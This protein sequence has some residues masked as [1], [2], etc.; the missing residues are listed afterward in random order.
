M[1][2]VAEN[3]SALGVPGTGSAEENADGFLKGLLAFLRL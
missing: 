2:E 1:R 3:V